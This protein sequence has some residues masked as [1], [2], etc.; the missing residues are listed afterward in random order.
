MLSALS[1]GVRRSA[2]RRLLA[3][4]RHLRMSSDSASLGEQNDV[5]FSREGSAGVMQL[6]RPKALN[7]L[8]LSMITKMAPQFKQWEKDDGVAFYLL[9]GLGGKAFCAGGDVRTLADA[10]KSS[11]LQAANAFFFNE[12]RLDYQIATLSKPVF[13][14]VDGIWMGGGVGITVHGGIRIATE[15]TTFAMPETAI[16]F[17]PDVGVS[18]VLARMPNNLGCYLALTGQ[19][20][21]GRDVLRAKLAT[22]LVSTEQLPSLVKELQSV[23][24]SGAEATEKARALVEKYHQS[25]AD[26]E[27]KSLSILLQHSSKIEEYFSGASVQEILAKLEESG[28]SWQSEQAAVIRKRC[29]LSLAVAW[30]QLKRNASLSLKDVFVSDYRLGGRLVL[31]PDFSEGVRAVLVEKD[32]KPKWTTDLSTVDTQVER[33]FAP[34]EKPED[35]WTPA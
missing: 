12:Y 7:S 19:S 27:G 10:G 26:V 3:V 14:F 8:N 16:G 11:D 31:H 30:E 22:H 29:P 6:N 9:S 4:S 32:H 21:R 34:L 35:E 33:F 15:R 1:S 2:V 24:A 28:E 5:L 13:A 20:L 25:S 17:F 18:H 23:C